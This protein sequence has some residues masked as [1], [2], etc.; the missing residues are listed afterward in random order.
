MAKELR[1]KRVAS[2]IQSEISKIIQNDMR[3]ENI[4]GMVSILD[5]E[6]SKDLRHANVKVSIFANTKE[7]LK[8]TIMSI[9]KAKSFIRRNL[10]KSL[11]TMYGPEIHF[12]FID[13]S[14]SMK[15][16]NILK[17]IEEE[18]SNDSG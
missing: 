12:D 13:L 10:S 14:E 1:V 17:E 6:V 4:K 16:Y 11:K 9:I 2:F 7:D 8:S 18:I 15:I 3:D 5:V